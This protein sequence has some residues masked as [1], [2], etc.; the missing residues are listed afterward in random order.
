MVYLGSSKGPSKRKALSCVSNMDRV[1]RFCRHHNWFCKV[2][3]PLWFMCSH[4]KQ[5][6]VR[7]KSE[8]TLLQNCHEACTNTCKMSLHLTSSRHAKPFE[9]RFVVV[10]LMSVKLHCYRTTAKWSTHKHKQKHQ[11]ILPGSLHT[12][13]LRRQIC[14]CGSHISQ[15]TLLQNH[16]EVKHPQTLAKISRHLTWQ[17]AREALR[18]RTCGCRSHPSLFAGSWHCGT[19]MLLACTSQSLWK[20]NTIFVSKHGA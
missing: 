12:K 7:K 3:L 5:L 20:M 4:L 6:A 2:S 10:D 8:T 19:G 13:S 1:G 17:P 11:G 16:C 15:T 18:G 9:D 14:G